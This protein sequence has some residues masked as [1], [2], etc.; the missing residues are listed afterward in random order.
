MLQNLRAQFQNQINPLL[1]KIEFLTLLYRITLELVTKLNVDE[2]NSR[3]YIYFNLNF[4]F[5]Y[6]CV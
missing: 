4:V 2:D 6:T 1:M 3:K 5:P